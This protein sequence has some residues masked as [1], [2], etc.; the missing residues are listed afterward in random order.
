MKNYRILPKDIVRREQDGSHHYFVGERYYSSVTHILDVAGPKEYGLLNFFKN[1]TPEQIEEIKTTTAGFGS[2]IHDAIEKLLFGVELKT[3]DYSDAQKKILVQFSDWFKTARPTQYLPEQVIVWDQAVENITDSMR[4]NMDED[5]ILP[6]LLE[7]NPNADRFA[8]TLDFLGEI[9]AENMAAMP[10]CFTTKAEL[11]AFQ[12]KYQADK[13]LLC[14]IDFKTTSGIYFSHKLQLG[15]YKLAAEQMFGRA[16]DVCAIVR[17]G[18]RHKCGYEMKM[19]D[20]YK[21][22]H[23]F[24]NVLDTYK[25]LN[26]GKLPDPPAIAVYPETIQLVEADFKEVA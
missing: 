23:T 17:F 13:K 18:T 1:N 25:M 6:H 21:F 4:E 7:T 9:S 24:M 2:T 19:V 20:G 16:I 8:G 15:A 22:A 11:A 26:N 12:A 5:K 3:S 14:L 10:N